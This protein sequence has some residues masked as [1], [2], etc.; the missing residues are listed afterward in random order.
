MHMHTK[1]INCPSRQDILT[2]ILPSYLP[3][4]AN[5]R[6]YPGQRLYRANTKQIATTAQPSFFSF[7]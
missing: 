4:L 7:S 5:T 3:Y 2:L 6:C 1:S